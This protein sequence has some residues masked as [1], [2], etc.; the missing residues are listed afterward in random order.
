MKLLEK[1]KSIGIDVS[2]LK[3][4]KLFNISVNV[5]RSV[6]IDLKNSAVT[7]NPA[8]LSG[9]QRRE[10][11]HYLRQEALSEC[12]VILHEKTIDTVKTVQSELPAIHKE[13]LLLQTVIPPADAPLMQ[14]CLYLR[15]RFQNDQKVD[16][17]KAQIVHA[18]GPRGRNFANLCSAGYLER[19]FKPVLDELNAA[20]PDNPATVKEKFLEFYNRVLNDL[21]WTE[22]VCSTTGKARATASIIAK[23][24]R[25]VETGVRFLNVHGL[26]D[27]N[28]K[29]IKSM[30]PEIQKTTGAVPVKIE[31]DK[32]SIFVRLEISE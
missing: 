12:G 10:V 28:V 19:W 6:H 4:I 30:L 25:N 8:E 9:K 20:Y 1:L 16:D 18:Y 31:Q 29:K 27:A 32:S 5:D 26:G 22:F 3:E 14:S 24:Q 17:L 23:M 2:K 7:I 21:P 15:N 11:Q 13:M